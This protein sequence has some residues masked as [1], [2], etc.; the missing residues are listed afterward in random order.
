MIGRR[1]PRDGNRNLLGRLGAF[2]KSDEKILG[3]E[4]G[5]ASR[6]TLAPSA[7]R[8]PGAQVAAVLLQKSCFH[9]VG[10]VCSQ[11]LMYHAVA[12]QRILKREQDF[13]ALMQ[14]ARHPIGAAEV[15]LRLA[16]VLE[17]K[18]SAVLKEPPHDAA[19]A[20]A[21]AGATNSRP[22]RAFRKGPEQPSIISGLDLSVL[23]VTVDS[24]QLK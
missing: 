4:C 21:V 15:D 8:L 19:H 23:M 11:N 12:Q 24:P 17:V 7:R 1:S 14:I 5:S 9:I 6:R 13:H 16:A 10:E 20:D 3:I 2:R 18:D 22:Q